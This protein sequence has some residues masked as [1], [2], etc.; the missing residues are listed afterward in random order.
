[1]LTPNASP[2]SSPRCS[3]FI[4]ISGIILFLSGLIVRPIPAQVLDKDATRIIVEKISAKRKEKPFIQAD[5]REEKSGGLLARPAI[6][7]GK[8]WYSAPN[9]FRKESHGEGKESIIVSNGDLLWMYYPAFQEAER[10]DLRKQKFINQGIAAFT[11]G[12]DFAQAE[13][14]FTIVAQETARGYSIEL[15][16]KRGPVSRM[17]ARLE[18]QLSKALELESVETQSPRGEK[19]R[20]ELSHIS[21][22]P[23]PAATFDFTPPAGANISNPLGK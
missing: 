3:S 15:T 19:I 1:M 6:S 22:E 8:M 9:K 12:L 4:R 11:S 16:P 21:V 23:I 10:Y 7:T 13:K 5:Y 14:D 20:T 18:V 17:L 2:I